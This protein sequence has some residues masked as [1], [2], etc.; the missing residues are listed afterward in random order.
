ML[1]PS[2]LEP[3]RY[4]LG[5]HKAAIDVYDEA[6]RIGVNDWEV[7]HNKGLCYMHLKMYDK[8]IDCF[9]NANELQRHDVTFVQLGKVSSRLCELTDRCG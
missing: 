3:S 9:T 7:W 4:L 5:K 2:P 6:Q 1:P 8:S